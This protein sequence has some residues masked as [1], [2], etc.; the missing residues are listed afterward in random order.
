MAR[1]S[2]LYRHALGWTFASLAGATNTY[3]P[4]NLTPE[5]VSQNKASVAV[6]LGQFSW[7]QWASVI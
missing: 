7:S 6:W 4:L 5:E 1:T 3:P 2:R